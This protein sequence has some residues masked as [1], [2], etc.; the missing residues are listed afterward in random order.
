MILNDMKDNYE[1]NQISIEKLFKK[2]NVS[3]LQKN[4]F[5]KIKNGLKNI[6]S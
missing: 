5:E 1:N 2:I 6:S 3:N 4:N